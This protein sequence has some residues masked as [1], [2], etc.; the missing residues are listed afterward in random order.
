[1]VVFMALL[2][3]CCYVIFWVYM[4]VELLCRGTLIVMKCEEVVID[5]DEMYIDCDE[6]GI[7]FEAERNSQESNASK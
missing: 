7:D 6:M 1:M 4:N 2:L 3:E 5:C